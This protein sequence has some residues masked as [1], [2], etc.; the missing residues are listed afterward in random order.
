ML[1]YLV[2]FGSSEGFNS[3]VFDKEGINNNFNRLFPDFE[4]FES[5]VFYTDRADNKPILAKY[6]LKVAGRSITLLKYYS[7]A[8]SSFSS[9]IEGSN[10][11]VAFLSEDDLSLNKIN[12][13]LLKNLLLKF[14]QKTLNNN[15]FGS[16]NFSK[17]ALEVFQE[18]KSTNS[19]SVIEKQHLKSDSNFQVIPC[20]FFTPDFS[21]DFFKKIPN[22]FDRI[23]LTTDKDH[24][25]RVYDSTSGRFNVWFFNENKLTNLT[26]QNELKKLEN[27]KKNQSNYN[28]SSGNNDTNYNNSNSYQ[29]ELLKNEFNQLKNKY[30]LVLKKNK[31]LTSIVAIL[32]ILLLISLLF[33]IFKGDNQKTEKPTSNNQNKIS[34]HLQTA[35]PGFNEIAVSF[36]DSIVNDKDKL[37]NFTSFLLFINSIKNE[38]ITTIT[39]EKF[40]EI[41]LNIESYG[42]F[43]FDETFFNK[44]QI[45]VNNTNDQNSKNIK[46]NKVVDDSKKISKRDSVGKK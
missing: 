9:R 12:F 42:I 4:H 44:H 37:K 15:K 45:N 2:F 31:L 38:K 43:E 46:D 32:S 18:F 29:N 3:E 8:Q 33:N 41:R 13:T 14:Q 26:E 11:G 40:D 23:Y 22:D 10:I 19:F 34:H 20:G 24:L 21:D 6:K 30:K 17:E 5:K 36:I 1:D 7:F 39:P 28:N 25:K 35:K 16:G 27:Y